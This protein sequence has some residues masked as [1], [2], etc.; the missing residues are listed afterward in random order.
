MKRTRTRGSALLELLAG[1]SLA[2]GWLGLQVGAQLRATY[3]QRRARH[4]AAAWLLANGLAEELSLGGAAPR[5][6]DAHGLGFHTLRED[7]AALGVDRRAA[8]RRLR[9]RL[10]PRGHDLEI[11]VRAP[12]A[13]ERRRVRLCGLGPPP[14]AGWEADS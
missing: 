3:H 4:R 8:L 13:R 1:A 5:P 7:L 6:A 2:I 14:A 11:E 9:I 12:G 10:A